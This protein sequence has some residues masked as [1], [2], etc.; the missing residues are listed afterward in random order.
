M[1]S[2]FCQ[3][4]KALRGVPCCLDFCPVTA[5]FLDSS[6]RSRTILQQ[7]LLVF[8]LL[9]L[10]LGFPSVLGAAPEFMPSAEVRPGMRGTGKTVFQGTTIDTFSVEILGVMPAGLGPGQD[11]ILARLS[12]G[13]LA[14]TGVIRGMSGSPVYV[15]GRLIGA[16]AY[17]WGF[18]KM[19][20]CGITPIQPMLQVLERGI[21]SP[22]EG[23]AWRSVEL[24]P[25]AAALVREAFPGVAGNSP[26]ALEPLATPVWVAGATPVASSA[27]REVLAPL[28]LQVMAAAGGGQEDAPAP[29]L[30]PGAALG[31]QLISGDLS[32]TAIG[33]LTYV[34][35]GQVIAFGHP[36]MLAGAT[37]MPMTGAQ[38][39]AIVPSQLTSFK[40]GTAT[41]AVGA[42]RQDRASA[43]AGVLG[44][45]AEML[46]LEVRFADA[47]HTSTFHFGIAYHPDLLSGLSRAALLAALESSAKV[48]G[49]ATLEVRSAIRLKGGELLEQ[50]QVYSGPTA[51]FTAAAEAASSLEALARASFAGLKPDSLRFALSL[52]ERIETAQVCGLRVRTPEV[53]AG[54]VVEV[55]V[56]LQPYRQEPVVQRL[57]VAL[58]RDLAPG[59]LLLRVGSGVA[60][61]AWE[62]QRRPDAFEPRDARQLLELL[63]YPGRGDELVVEL[64]RRESS[65]TVDGRELPGL[66]PSARLVLAAGGSA[67]HL[68]PVNGWVVLRQ[69]LRTEYVLSGEQSLELVV[70]KP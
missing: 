2:I 12:G 54:E 23:S 33:T 70:G 10:G 21:E 50:E 1:K 22:P 60:S 55:E 65:F 38:I 42:V 18:A 66:P 27:L 46:P 31:V 40:V 35:G 68:G 59:P 11:L 47:S 30:E 6:K 19:P 8:A 32:V 64:Y 53:R 4:V 39:H 43:I 13:P 69:R 48:F 3:F 37:D 15:D 58:P 67:G 9:G 14:E 52:R 29:P 57:K 17:G 51:I 5:Y 44:A 20:V 34:E 26:A 63:A 28:G 7:S 56:T 41:Q 62:S 16:V 45:A 25:A 49:D 24:D 36:M 61:R